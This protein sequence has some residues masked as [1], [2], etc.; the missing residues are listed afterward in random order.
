MFRNKAIISIVHFTFIIKNLNIK[1]QKQAQHGSTSV[2]CDLFHMS[3]LYTCEL[4]K[5]SHTCFWQLIKREY[6]QLYASLP[7][8]FVEIRWG[9][10]NLYW[11][12]LTSVT[13]QTWFYDTY[14]NIQIEISIVCGGYIHI[15][16][17]LICFCFFFLTIRL[18]FK[19]NFLLLMYPSRV[20]PL[21]SSFFQPPR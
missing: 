2:V 14:W 10:Y 4:D 15:Y 13:L 12:T 17:L 3:C 21:L 9:F 18:L 20:C 19:K 1:W 6:V 5:C 7:P 8:L 16:L 11:N